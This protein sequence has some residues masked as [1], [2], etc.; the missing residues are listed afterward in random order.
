GVSAS[1]CW[2]LGLF[3][4][5]GRAGRDGEVAVAQRGE[6]A[7][8]VGGDGPDD[9]RRPPDGDDV[10]RQRRPRR[11]AGALAEED[12]VPEPGAGHEDRSVPDLAEVA[13]D[14]SDHRAEVAEDAPTPDDG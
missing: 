13:R 3:D 11:N 10:A 4:G 7:E 2:L 9:P 12:A 8:I 14:C 6:A 1:R 5:D